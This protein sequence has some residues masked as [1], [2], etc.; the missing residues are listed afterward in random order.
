MLDA[1]GGEMEETCMWGVG[2]G[3][4]RWGGG[5][6]GCRGVRGAPPLLPLPLR[7]DWAGNEN[8]LYPHALMAST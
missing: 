7:L 8:D 5:G 4:G 1:G 2:G 3:G 6:R